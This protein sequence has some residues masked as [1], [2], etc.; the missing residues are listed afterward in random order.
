MENYRANL[1]SVTQE[2][3]D[4]RVENSR[5]QSRILEGTGRR[6]TQLRSNGQT[7]VVGVMQALKVSH[8]TSS[9]CNPILQ[10]T[11]DEA[12]D[13]LMEQAME[14]GE[15]NVCDRVITNYE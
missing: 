5:G 11:F 4:L 8:K 2:L 3:D 7:T 6:A 1:E 9:P 10:K 15:D 12:L 14:D 13:F